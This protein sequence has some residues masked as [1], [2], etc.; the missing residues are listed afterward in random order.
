ML[1]CNGILMETCKNNF[2]IIEFKVMGHLKCS[3][4]NE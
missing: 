2:K 1:T 3:V 4:V